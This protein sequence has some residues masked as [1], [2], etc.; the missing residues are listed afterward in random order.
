VYSSYEA[1]SLVKGR[2]GGQVVGLAA[3]CQKGS[4][5]Q[6]ARVSRYE[7]AVETFGGGT[8]SE[9]VKAILA[10]GATAVAAVP[11]AD[12]AG[13]AAAFAALEAVEDVKL[14]V[15]DS[16]ALSVQQALRD[17]VMAASAARKERLGVVSGV[18]GET[19][20]QL[21][22]RAGNLNCERMLLVAPSDG[23]ALAAAAVAGAIAGESDPALP[24]GGAELTEVGPLA[25]KY[26]D[27]EVD[28]LVRGGVTALEETAG[29]VSVIRGVTTR[30]KTGESGD[31]TWRE[32]STVRI[33]DDVIPAVRESLRS[34][35]RR[36]KNTP[37]S[38]G[39]IR[40]Q[41][42][43]ELEN[44]VS[45][46][47]IAGY[48]AVTVTAMEEDPTVCLVEFSFTVAHGLNQIWLSAHITV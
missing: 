26:T 22:A 13:Y 25:V 10:N 32:L 14:V 18:K 46:D 36:A 48:D 20:S 9:L 2:S 42:I 11:V 31:T 8:F 30:T 47:I 6:A 43:V 41:V 28:L 45:R 27:N 5:G 21:T 29:V 24:L 7:E 3:L 37:Q 39:A 35:F 1:S 38:R 34:K 12:E 33:V 40:S 17:S 23:T 44:R 19:V 16:V 4:A 15:C